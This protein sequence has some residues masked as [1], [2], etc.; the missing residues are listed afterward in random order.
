MPEYFNLYDYLLSDERLSSIGESVAI[1]F[2]GRTFS[3]NQL[4][5]EVLHWSGRMINAG[6]REGDR[7]ALY[8][9]DSPEFIACF[10]AAASL[11]LISVPIN[12]YLSREDVLFILQDCDAKLVIAETDLLEKVGAEAPLVG[13]GRGLVEVDTL[14]RPSLDAH[15]TGGLAPVR[16][17]TT[18]ATAAFILY[19]SGST[20]A[21]KG[22]LHNHGSIRASVETY[23]A[24]V[25]KLTA[26][27]RVYSASRAFFAY[28]LGNSLS[29][30]LAAGARAILHSERPTPESVAKVFSQSRPTVF[31]G[32][33]SLYRSLIDMSSDLDA[34]SLRLCV[35]AGEA[36][37]ARVLEDWR[38]RTGLTILDGIGSTEMLHVF[39][40]NHQGR[41]RADC[42]G[43]VVSGYKA[44]IRDDDGNDLEGEALGRLW[45]R[46][47]SAFVEYWNLPD[48]SADVKRDG[49]VSTGDIY[50]RDAEGYFYHVGRSDDCFKVKGLWVSPIEVESVLL[51]HEDIS[52]V[53][54]VAD[55]DSSGLA[56]AHAFVVIRTGGER[57]GLEGELRA[58]AS[59]SLP[60][61][62]VPAQIT[63]TS[64]L[65]R[66]AT[67][68]VQR[69]KLRRGRG[70]TPDD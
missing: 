29:F 26:E 70:T 58:F 16:P 68:K 34:S 1:E 24:S 67:G 37:P 10:L 4:R 60:A 14:S 30:P 69:F 50:R 41:E 32:V 33:P 38:R 36:L 45:V 51:K 53:A 17:Q 31:F 22:V 59:G 28:G 39:I 46:G 63:F 6:A 5:L 44:N 43:T 12:T 27:D 3:Y 40:S 54:V 13:E 2:R 23:A 55:F 20:G 15:R 62:K 57:A 56:T 48:L 19:T 49:W 25:L 52:E 64:E 11:G 66:T 61:H 9:Y 65:P 7:V 18:A 35:S 21:P 47:D 8:L 42:S